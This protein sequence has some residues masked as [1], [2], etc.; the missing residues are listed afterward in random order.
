[1][2][3]NVR[4]D[5]IFANLIRR[6]ELF[7]P[8]M[9]IALL[10]LAG[11]AFAD[12]VIIQNK[13]NLVIRDIKVLGGKDNC[14]EIRYSSDITVSNV[15]LKNCHGVGVAITGSKNITIKS[16]Y[17]ENLNGG[18][19]AVESEGVK[20]INNKFRNVSRKGKKSQSRGQ[21]VQFNKVTGPGNIISSNIGV[22]EPH[23][24]DT[25]DLVNLFAS[26]GTLSEPIIVEDNCFKGGGPSESGGGL[27]SGDFQGGNI[28]VRNNTLVDVGQYGVGV[29]GG[30]NIK[31]L[32]NKIFGRQ[33]EF[34]NVG[35]YVWN[36]TRKYGAC[37]DIVVEG[38]SV[39][40]RNK[41]GKRNSAWNAGNCGTVKGWKN[42]EWKASLSHL[43]CEL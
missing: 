37:K 39:D 32:N 3:V 38:N 2:I 13:Q 36:I 15:S 33:Q 35:I 41:L 4:C 25:E 31:I 23:Q 10:V 24:S 43:N 1:M 21:F 7:F 28:I 12:P 8:F 26:K 30:Q 22:N 5:Y 14:I 17:F 16:S 27:M 9:T 19:Y 11:S 29:A 6:L 20:V 42:N 34:T 40:Y 18:V